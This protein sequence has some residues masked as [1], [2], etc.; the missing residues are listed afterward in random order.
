M[1]KKLELV[2][3][4]FTD[5]FVER[6]CT[7]I[8]DRRTIW[9]C[10]CVCGDKI[11]VPGYRLTTGHTKRCRK[12]GWKHSGEKRK[13]GEL[14]QGTWRTII[15]GAKSRDIALMITKEQA[16][17][18]FI[19]QNRKCALTGLDIQLKR[20]SGD[21]RHQ[22]SASLDRIDSN[23]DYSVG[24]VQWVHKCVNMLKRSMPEK[25]FVNWCCLIADYHRNKNNGN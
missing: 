24:N 5:L 8:G 15:N 23:G 9:C 13:G 22:I 14:S 21:M 19:T 7:N 1:S 18:K 3:Q 2:G 11:I 16:L 6:E 12:C 25:D 10:K 17:E 20:E 4:K